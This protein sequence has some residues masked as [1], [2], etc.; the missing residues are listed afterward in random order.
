MPTSI[1]IDGYNLLHVTGIFGRGVGPGT[2]HRSRTALLN[3]LAESIA[4]DD[5]D[6]TTIVFDSAEAPPGLPRKVNH[7]GMTVHF[8]SS[9]ADADELIEELIVQ[10][11]APRTLVVVSSDHRI[12]RAARRRKATPIDSDRWFADLMRE[13]QSRH[14]PSESTAAKPPPPESEHEIRFWL[15]EFGVDDPEPPELKPPPT[16]REQYNPFPPGYAE[17]IDDE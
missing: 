11:Q 13:R 17:D 7:R 6:H 1:L 12:H 15:A 10:H 9:Y 4:P 8:A 14:D 2:L 3:V 16:P 5:V